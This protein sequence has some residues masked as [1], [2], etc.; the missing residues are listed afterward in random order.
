MNYARGAVLDLGGVDT[1][2]TAQ[3]HRRWLRHDDSQVSILLH[4]LLAD[5]I[6]WLITVGYVWQQ[7]ASPEPLSKVTI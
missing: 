4:Y 5:N 6:S 7:A 1:N 2:L 3:V